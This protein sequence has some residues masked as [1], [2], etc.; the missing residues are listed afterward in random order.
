[1][2]LHRLPIFSSQL[3]SFH[4]VFIGRSQSINN[5]Y[6]ICCP[7]L[8]YGRRVGRILALFIKAGFAAIWLSRAQPIRPCTTFHSYGSAK[9]AA[10]LSGYLCLHK[11]SD[12]RESIAALASAVASG[13]PSKTRPTRSGDNQARWIRLLT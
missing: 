12:L 5:V 3:E 1:L 2:N 13:S 11:T 8:S 10:D 9:P 7:R 6:R 4:Y